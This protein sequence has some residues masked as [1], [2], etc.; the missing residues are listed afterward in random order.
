MLSSAR[1]LDASPTL[2]EY[3][4]HLR[5]GDRAWSAM[6]ELAAYNVAA[7][8]IA[9]DLARSAVEKLKATTGRLPWL[10]KLVND[11]QISNR[12]KSYLARAAELYLW[13]FD[14][15]CVVMCRGIL[16]AVL[17]DCIP[18]EDLARMGFTRP[19][20]GYDLSQRITAAVRLERLSEDVAGWANEVRRGANDALH[21]AP[22][23]AP[24]S[25]VTLS[26]ISIILRELFP[27]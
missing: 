8:R 27:E 18:D 1:V 6:S 17:Q 11:R 19:K 23:V 15:E 22:G 24:D 21:L 16:D 14:V 2:R 7:D 4:R 13:E 25:L 10:L 5:P 20:Y 12:A 26:L 3:L 9:I